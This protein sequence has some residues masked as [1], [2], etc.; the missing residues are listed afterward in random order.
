MEPRVDA[1]SSVNQV[2]S[3]SLVK[4]EHDEKQSAP[5]DGHNQ[6]QKMLQPHQLSS[7]EK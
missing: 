7:S 3:K 2:S 6:A 1:K 5:L 4:A